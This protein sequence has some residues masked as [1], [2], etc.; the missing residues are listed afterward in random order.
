ML[1]RQLT[2]KCLL[3]KNPPFL[4][5]CSV[6]MGKNRHPASIAGET[7]KHRTD[8]LQP[9]RALCNAHPSLQTPLEGGGGERSGHAVVSDYAAL[10]ILH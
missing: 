9:P 7:L 5:S 3:F 2:Q 8:L 4:F 1:G 6:R 10:Q